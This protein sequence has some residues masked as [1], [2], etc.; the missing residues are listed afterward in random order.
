MHGS[1]AVPDLPPLYASGER[2][3]L[4]EAL[5]TVHPATAAAFLGELPPAEV[6]ALL[7]EMDPKRAAE[8]FAALDDEFQVELVSEEAPEQVAPVVAELPSDDRADIIRAMD[9]EVRYSVLPL[10][11][12]A[13]REN[14]RRLASY[15]EETAGALMTT[16][17]VAL[18]EDTLVQ[19]ALERLRLEAPDKET[20]YYVYVLDADRH[21]TGLVSLK[22]LILAKPK[23]TT[24]GEI[25]HRDIVAVRV[26]QDQE[27]VAH[28]LSDYDFLAIPVVDAETRLVGIVT[29]DDAMDVIEDEAQEDLFEMASVSTEESIDTPLLDSVRLRYAWLVINLFTAI[30]AALTVGLFESSIAQFTALAVMMPIIAGMGGNAGTQTMAVAVRGLALGEL[31]FGEAW[32]FLGKE[33]GVGFAN[34]MITGLLMAVIA[35]TW[36][37]NLWLGLIMLLAMIGNLMIAGLCGAAFPLLLKACGKDPALASTIFITTA[38][39]VGGFLVF[40][41]LA[42]LFL[43]Y[44]V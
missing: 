20:I 6:W 13:E 21:L 8:L 34:G 2:T 25:A 18:R 9:D 30:L 23:R 7:G 31:S 3:A 29:F 32:R 26:D 15:E 42:T 38:T 43:H 14:I 36:Y 10:I 39:D 33:V 24:V 40:L 28:T 27:E 17:Y 35:A 41:G 19:D 11:A 22:D 16:D 4:R 44:L 1:I 12:R 5:Q 37:G